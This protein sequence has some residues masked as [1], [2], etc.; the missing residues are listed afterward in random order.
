MA[1]RLLKIFLIGAI[2]TFIFDL[3]GAN[4]NTDTM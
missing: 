1:S 3:S 4:F 2:V